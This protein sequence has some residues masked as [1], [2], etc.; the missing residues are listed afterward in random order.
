MDQFDSG[1]GFGDVF[2]CKY[3]QGYKERGVKMNPDTIIYICGFIVAVDRVFDIYLKYKSRAES[4]TKSLQ[5]RIEKLE[6]DTEKIYGFL[7]RDKTRLDASDKG[8]SMLQKS[9][10][11]LIDN[12]IDDSDKAPLLE[13]KRDL[14]NFL[15][16]RQLNQ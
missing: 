11:A 1:H 15:I 7:A 9:I 14:N 12:A 2:D 10:L 5:E 3:H 16:E 8:M 13:A 6:E 4:P